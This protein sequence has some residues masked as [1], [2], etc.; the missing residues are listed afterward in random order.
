MKQIINGVEVELTEA[1][2]EEKAQAE[3]ASA[4][5]GAKHKTLEKIFQLENSIT[6]RM[7][8]EALTDKQTKGLGH[9]K[10][11][12]AKAY[13]TSIIDQIAVERA[14]LEG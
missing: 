12:T 8:L 3:L 10:Q 2:L 13:I 5:L 4:A 6:K 9:D 7:L 1:E 14:K 11:L